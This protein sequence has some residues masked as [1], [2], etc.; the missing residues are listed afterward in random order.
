MP[1]VTTVSSVLRRVS[2]RVRIVVAITS[3][4]CLTLLVSFTSTIS[5]GARTPA[6]HAAMET[7]ATLTAVLAAVLVYG[8]YGRGLQR[9]DLVLTVGLAV[10]AVA[11]FGLCTVPAIA[12]SAPAVPTAWASVISRAVG[13][14]LFA[15]A[16]F[17]PPDEVRRP[18]LAT[19]RWFG[20]GVLVVAAVTVASM[21]AGDRLPAPVA[22][23][24]TA[25]QAFA[26]TAALTTLGAIIVL[27][28]GAATLGF[29]RRVA[30][31]GDALLG[32]L[33]V[34][35]VF[36]TF[37]WLNY[38]IYPSVV[39]DWF[40]AGDLLR[41]GFFACLL[42]GGV[43]ELRRGQRALAEAAVIEERQRMA[44]DLHDGSAQDLAF[45]AHAARALRAGGDATAQLDQIT[46]AAH[47]ALEN[48]RQ[49][50]ADFARPS[51]EP[52]TLAL[53]RTAQDVAGR[54]GA[55]VEV[56][57]DADVQVPPATRE[58][59][60]RLV[61]EAVSNAVRHGGATAVRVTV[62]ET[63]ELR[64]V[65]GDDGCG[66]DPQEVG[67]PSQG[68]GLTGMVQRVRQLGGELRIDS[69]PGRGTQ[70]LVTLP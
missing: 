5:P 50:I 43:T 56:D 32:W 41:F 23:G 26:G 67:R 2:L 15:A 48:T 58:A 27:L 42:A 57:G 14:A 45:I 54:A 70:V 65:I 10:F 40:A 19:R 30:D 16:A 69:E 25:G 3:A 49:A 9:R 35:S 11:N 29:A 38:V 24:A 4:A 62:R 66:F 12:T 1:K 63:P 55:R 46:I 34:G 64:V 59:L 60:C 8:R 53:A 47:H 36:G 39:T 51:T 44:R 20:A 61:R 68:F 37:A 6:L 33:A 31:T 7:G 28:F 21:L 18:A 22:E 52:L 13:A 17:L